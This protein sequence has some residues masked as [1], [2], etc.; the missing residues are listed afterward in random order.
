MC[1]RYRQAGALCS[2]VA[3][4]LRRM[5]NYH[6]SDRAERL[7]RMVA[8]PIR[9]RIF[10]QSDPV[11]PQQLRL[12]R[13]ARSRTGIYMPLCD[14]S[15]TFSVVCQGSLVAVARSESPVQLAQTGMAYLHW[16]D[17][18]QTDVPCRPGHKKTENKRQ[19]VLTLFT[20]HGF[21]RDKKARPSIDGETKK[22][23]KEP[24]Q[25]GRMLVEHG[26]TWSRAWG[27]CSGIGSARSRYRFGRFHRHSF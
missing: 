26:V 6:T 25:L 3:D 12:T 17:T 16:S 9:R 7:T 23:Q 8:E 11:R 24:P 19:T 21:K 14:A 20:S 4:T 27:K 22:S 1:N 10:G 18:S 15:A 5:Q 2:S 13:R